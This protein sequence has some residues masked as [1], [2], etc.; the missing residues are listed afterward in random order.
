MAHPCDRQRITRRR[1]FG[2]IPSSAGR[3]NCCG[4]MAID[5]GSHGYSGKVVG[6]VRLAVARRVRRIASWSCWVAGGSADIG[7][8][9][10]VGAVGQDPVCDGS[11]EG[12]AQL[13]C[14]EEERC[15]AST[16]LRL[17]GS[18]GLQNEKKHQE[19]RG[20]SQSHHRVEQQTGVET[21]VY[22]GG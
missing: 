3:N 14:R 16:V 15:A 21:M 20:T 10:L 22:R 17:D 8:V 19:E 9:R 2:S 12:T 13:E 7:F 5:L 4:S 1:A 18:D 11:E 6:F